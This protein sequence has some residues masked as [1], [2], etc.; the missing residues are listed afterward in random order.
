MRLISNEELVLVGGGST[1][2]TKTRAVYT[3]M[4]DFAGYEEYDDGVQEVEIIGNR[5]TDA[6]KSAYDLRQ[7]CDALARE[8]FNNMNVTSAVPSGAYGGEAGGKVALGSVEIN[9]KGTGSRTIP[10]ASAT[11]PCRP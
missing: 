4:G 8:G 1:K 7:Y 2:T 3:P 6:E 5:M 9:L 11:G 10:G